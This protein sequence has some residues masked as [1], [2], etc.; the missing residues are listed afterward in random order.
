MVPTR[1]LLEALQDWAR[2]GEFSDKIDW[3]TE[4]FL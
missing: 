2:S 4:L 3:T 1:K